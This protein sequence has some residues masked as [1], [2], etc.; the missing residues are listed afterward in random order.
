MGGGAV[1]YQDPPPLPLQLPSTTSS[2]GRVEQELRRRGIL[3]VRV[4]GGQPE[5]VW[6]L[7]GGGWPVKVH[8]RLR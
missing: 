4:S 7:L 5:I 6:I 2:T 3:S 8:C 1:F